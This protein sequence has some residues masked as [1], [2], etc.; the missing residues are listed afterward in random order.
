MLPILQVLRSFSARRAAA[1]AA[2]RTQLSLFSLEARDQPSAAVDL[3]AAAQFGVLGLSRTD[4]AN[5]NSAVV[6][7]VGAAQRGSVFNGARATITGDVDEFRRGQYAGHGQ[8][9]GA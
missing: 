1:R 5:E 6:G 7:S 8:V 9:G 3:G 2:L 4:I